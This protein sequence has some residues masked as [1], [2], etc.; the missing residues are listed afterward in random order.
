[1][2]SR[3][4]QLVRRRIIKNRTKQRRAVQQRILI[5]HRRKRRLGIPINYLKAQTNKLL[6]KVKELFI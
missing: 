1:M 6:N 2:V 5:S 4:A 3:Q